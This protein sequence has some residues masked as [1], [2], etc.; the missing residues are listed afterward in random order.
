[1]LF[2]LSSGQT[3]KS[4][5][6]S[7]QPRPLTR[8]N[9]AVTTSAQSRPEAGQVGRPFQ[10]Q[11]VFVT[12]HWSV[13]L[14]ARDQASPECADALETLCRV[15]WYPLYAYARWQGRSPHDAEDLTQEFFAR[16]L[17]K[18][19]LDAV[20]PAR[21]RFRTFL[22]VAFKRFMADE[23]DR[24]QTQKR[25]GGAAPIPFDTALAEQL[26]QNEP[27]PRLPA[28]RMYEHRWALALLE[29]TMRR[30]RAEFDMAGKGEEFDRLKHFLAVG[31][32]DIPGA[33]PAG[34]EGAGQKDGTLRV[35]VHRLRKRFR[36]I[37]RE[38]IAQTVARPED[39]EEELRHL[40]A[41]LSE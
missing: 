10:R 14:S 6:V 28:E 1:M 3:W 2:L 34:S 38:E 29:Q 36:Q 4:F 26:Y 17:Q 31:K 11:P 37:F 18:N 24:L 33:A 30:L 19:Y 35:A 20:E 7:H 41:V 16:L 32:A 8:G 9:V 39:V 13:V 27:P 40:L 25:G 21:G 12:T 22:R 23:W 15:Y 5:Y